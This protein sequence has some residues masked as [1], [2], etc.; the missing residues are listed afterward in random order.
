MAFLFGVTS[1][2]IAWYT[3]RKV[4]FMDITPPVLDNQMEKNM[5]NALEMGYLVDF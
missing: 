2:R 1:Y 5:E 4:G 3:R